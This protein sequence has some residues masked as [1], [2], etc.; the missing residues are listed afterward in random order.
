MINIHIPIHK[1]NPLVAHTFMIH[2][3]II[4]DS[5]TSVNYL[6]PEKLRYKA[7]SC[8]QLFNKSVGIWYLDDLL[9]LLLIEYLFFDIHNLQN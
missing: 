6:D 9:V 2:T 5:V 3:Y 1:N 7:D 8:A 4:I